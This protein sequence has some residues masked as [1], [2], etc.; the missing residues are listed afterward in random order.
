M[1]QPPRR[2]SERQPVAGAALL[3]IARSLR[4]IKVLLVLNPLSFV[5]L[6]ALDVV[7]EQGGTGEPSLISFVLILGI[8]VTNFA[9]F[10]AVFGAVWRLPWSVAL[11][12]AI[13]LVALVP[14]ANLLVAMLVGHRG[15][16]LLRRHSVSW[17]VWGPTRADVVRSARRGAAERR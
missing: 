1:S 10:I 2:P 8:A 13:T 12:L 7:F 9:L 16:A 4:A 17:G 6:L 11:Q 3:G 5:G 15:A 14:L